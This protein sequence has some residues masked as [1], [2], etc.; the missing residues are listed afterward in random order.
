M[1]LIGTAGW[2]IPAK[3]RDRFPAGGS[4]LQRYATV[5]DAVEINA[6]FYRPSRASTL[7]RWREATP[8]AF[9]F[10]L[11]LA[12][13]ITHERRL[14]DCAD[15]IDRFLAETAPLGHKRG[16]ILIQ[17]P[18]SLGF[19][20]A[21]AAGFLAGFRSRYEGKAALEPRHA[22]W[23]NA[24]ADALLREHRV[25]RVAADPARTPEAARPGGWSGLRYFRLHGSPRMYVTPYGVERLAPLAATLQSGDWV[26]FDNTM[27]GAAVEDALLLKAL[28]G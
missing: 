21:V 2:Q 5:F 8:E 10:S 13:A 3:V 20:A 17:L 22:S 16:P 24:E 15:L 27:S 11:K 7:E 28:A 25:A 18:P 14:V 9:R 12:R 4:T 6:T 26:M 19:D 23:F 1:P